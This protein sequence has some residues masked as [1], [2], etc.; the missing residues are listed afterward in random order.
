M[1]NRSPPHTAEH[2]L[3]APKPPSQSTG[4]IRSE[5]QPSW[6]CSSP[7]CASQVSSAPPRPA[8]CVTLYT[9]RCTPPLPHGTLQ[10]SQSPQTPSQSVRQLLRSHGSHCTAPPVASHV[11][12]LPPANTKHRYQQR[13][14]ICCQ[15]AGLKTTPI[16]IWRTLC[17]GNRYDVRALRH[18]VARAR[19]CAALPVAPCSGAVHRAWVRVACL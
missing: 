19:V 11:H 18:S 14:F 7:F 16:K 8:G 12:A 10:A 17:R 3:H 6:V 5:L 4:Q 1:K 15:K 2:S 13:G 9:R